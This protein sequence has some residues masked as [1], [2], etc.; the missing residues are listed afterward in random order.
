MQYITGANRDQITLMPECLD[1]YVGEDNVVRVIDVFVER[2]DL[3]GLGFA[4]TELKNCGRPPYDPAMLLKLYIYGYM[5]RT[6]SSRRLQNMARV[7]VEAMWLLGKVVPDDRCIADFRKDNGGAIKKVFRE[8]S[9]MCSRLGLYGGKDTSVDGTKIRANA[10]RHSV[11]TQ[12]GTEALIKKVNEKIDRYMKMLDETDA[13]EADEPQISRETVMSILEFLAEKKVKLLDR[14]KQIEDNNGE[15]VGAVDPDARIMRT[16]GDGRPLDACYNV[17][18]I[19]DNKHSIVLEFEVTNNSGD[20]GNLFKMTKAAKEI[21]ETP[22]INVSADK[23]YYDS[24]DIAKREQNQMT[25]YVPPVK[26][27]EQAPDLKYDRKNF[28]YDAENDCY[29]CPDGEKLSYNPAKQA[30]ESRL[31]ENP[32]ACKNCPN[33]TKCTK[34]SKRRIYRLKHQEALERNNARMKTEAGKEKYRERSQTIEHI[35]GTIKAV[36][37]YR[38][39]LCRT[40]ERTTAEQSLAFLAYNL[41]RAANIFA[42]SGGKL[43]EAM[44]N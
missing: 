6:R 39:F 19:A 32:K 5:N 34:A 17:Q 41:R 1:D 37:G 29:N 13:A 14:K 24:K 23:G 31:Y 11:Y 27:S 8:F 36:W 22:E 20:S 18:T 21:L 3:G 28:R 12:K 35:F 30:K 40:K 38:Q 9:L 15:T 33:R 16:N 42:E 26:V 44:T 43:A 2:L 4:K 7:N 10:N 25:V